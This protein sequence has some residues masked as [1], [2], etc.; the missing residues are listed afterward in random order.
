MVLTEGTT[1]VFGLAAITH[2]SN[3]RRQPTNVFLS[4]SPPDSLL[5][6]PFPSYRATMTDS[7]RLSLPIDPEE[8]PIEG[9][10][11]QIR[12]SLE[13]LK[14]DKS[15][16]VKSEDVMK[17]YEQVIVQVNALNKLRENKRDEQNRGTYLSPRQSVVLLDF[18]TILSLLFNGFHG[19]ALINYIHALNCTLA[20]IS[21][22][23]YLAHCTGHA[24]FEVTLLTR[25][26]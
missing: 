19:K 15:N 7:P 6:N 25:S 17:M 20:N 23:K 12:N 1:Q 26:S 5:H 4:P 21:V 3:N 16:Y 14:A 2:L 8:R 18:P 22:S 24:T 13:L 9:A 11:L 10:L